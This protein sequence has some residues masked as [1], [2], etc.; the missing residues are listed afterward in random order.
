MNIPYNGSNRNSL[1]I[2]VKISWQ[3][4]NDRLNWKFFKNKHNFT[5]SIPKTVRHSYMCSAWVTYLLN[6]RRAMSYETLCIIV[7]KSILSPCYSKDWQIYILVHRKGCL[8]TGLKEVFRLWNTLYI[9]VCSLDLR[10]SYLFTY[11]IVISSS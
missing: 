6:G 7:E 3:I 5:P 11:Y 4:K 10:L 1:R 9:Y 8:L 2:I